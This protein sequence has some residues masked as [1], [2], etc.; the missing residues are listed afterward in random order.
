MAVAWVQGT[1]NASNGVFNQTLTVTAGNCL[2][3]TCAVRHVG[4]LSHGIPNV[5]DTNF[6]VWQSPV[7]SGVQIDGGGN[8]W[9]LLTY[10][11]FNCNGG[12][13]TITV[14]QVAGNV[15][16][17]IDEYSGVGHAQVVNNWSFNSSEFG[18]PITTL[19][20]GPVNASSGDVVYS[21]A[22]SDVLAQT[23]TPS[24]G[25]TQ[26]Q[27]N[28]YSIGG[29]FLSFASFDKSSAGGSESNTV[30]LGSSANTEH[31]TMLVLQASGSSGKLVQMHCDSVATIHTEILTVPYLYA[32]TAGNILIAAA[33]MYERTDGVITDS[34]GNTWTM[35]YTDPAGTNDTLVLA[36]ALNCNAG[37]NIV[38]LD[39]T[40]GGD[41][42]TELMII[43]EYDF[44]GLFTSSSKGVIGSASS[45]DSGSVPAI[46]GDL[47][48]STLS[49]ASISPPPASQLETL[50][51]QF[52]DPGFIRVNHYNAALADVVAPSDGS[53]NNVF[54]I[55]PLSGSGIAAILGFTVAP[56]P[57]PPPTPPC[58]GKSPGGTMPSVELTRDLNADWDDESTFYITQSEP[59]PFTL[60]GIVMRMSYNQD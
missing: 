9:Q 44:Q 37:P 19:T 42:G 4:D 55:T 3:L 23:Y 5:T 24:A 31:I 14:H 57:P 49:L 51:Y 50:R 18:T 2:V 43:A 34:N 58:G 26:R 20:A 8:S 54:D 47:L 22:M 48:I 32:N 13:T 11:A 53:Y 30:A 41:D 1:S 36:Y 60:R 21:A 10:V 45:F 52:S 12:S 25:Y 35:V 59:F 7:M 27:T 40:G 46:T 15:L 56:T 33:F 39:G 29:F 16:V 17:S 6:N 38:T 28:A